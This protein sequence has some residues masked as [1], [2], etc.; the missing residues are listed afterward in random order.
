MQININGIQNSQQ[1]IIHLLKQRNVLVACIQETKL[2]PASSLPDFPNFAA[3]RR[4]RPGRGGGG[5]ITLV[6][7]S[8]TYTEFDTSNFFPGDTVAECLAVELEMGGAKLLVANVYIPPVSSC[9]SDYSPNFTHLFNWSDD[10]L[11]MG[12]FNAHDPRWYST[13][14]DQGA[15]ARGAAICDALDTGTLT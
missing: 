15:A 6:H 2:T 13:T 11:V 1:E 10:I 8:I 12:D 4:D 5:L 14:L 9:P 3:V 7:H